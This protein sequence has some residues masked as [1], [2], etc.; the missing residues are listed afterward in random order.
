VCPSKTLDGD[1]MAGELSNSIAAGRMQYRPQAG[2]RVT[3]CA[4]VVGRNSGCSPFLSQGVETFVE[5]DQGI[6]FS[7]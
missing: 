6:P 1:Q 5:F 4:G 3:S 2:G 7:H